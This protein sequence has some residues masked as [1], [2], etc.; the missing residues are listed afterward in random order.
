MTIDA[1]NDDL[2]PNLL[3]N[4]RL[5]LA[6]A[7]D[8][9]DP[10]GT[11]DIFK[12]NADGTLPINLTFTTQTPYNEIEPSWSPD[13][14]KIA[15]ASDQTGN[16]EIFIMND[17][18][19]S[20]TQL[21]TQTASIDV[22]PAI[23]P[24]GAKIAFVSDRDGDRALWEMGIA[25]GSQTKLVDSSGEDGALGPDPFGLGFGLSTPSWSP[26]GTKLA[27]SSDRSGNV[28]IYV[29]DYSAGTA[30]AQ[31]GASDSGYD[32]F[33]PFWLPGGD[34]IAFVADSDGDGDREIW[35]VDVTTGAKSKLAE[36]GDNVTPAGEPSKG[37]GLSLPW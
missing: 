30:T 5:K 17:D 16:W 24:D 18:G 36:I 2:W 27:F 7:S 10:G 19:S 9:D 1:G 4:T 32:E 22:A 11:F 28:D 8:R 33:S 31:S 21:T 29:Y 23:S 34:W 25:G 14:A 13:G 26:D 3:P 37:Q 35:K 20:L 12:S 6:F 15:F